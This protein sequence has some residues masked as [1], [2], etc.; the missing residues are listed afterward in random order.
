MEEF[1]NHLLRFGQL[2][3]QQ[4]DFIKSKVQF[5]DIKKGSYFSE[6]GKIPKQV[7]FVV[8]GVLRVCCYNNKHEDITRLFII[9]NQFALD[10]NSFYSETPSAVYLE[11][12]TDCKLLA[13]T[14]SSFSEL[15]DSIIGFSDI[16]FRI[17]SVSL[18][19]KLKAS[20]NMLIQDA[21]NRYE[22]FLTLYPGLA[23][24]IPLSTIASYLGITQS[25]LSRIRKNI[26]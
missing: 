9:E 21:K 3:L 4:I 1:I 18:T 16:F 7:G 22:D 20:T 24:R 2:N 12:V 8:S 13:L 25:S 14:K 26:S 10:F 11:A 17:T 15:S 6:A 23:N 5:I 19:H